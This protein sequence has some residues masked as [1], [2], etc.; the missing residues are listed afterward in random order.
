[1]RHKKIKKILC[2]S[3]LGISILCNTTGCGVLKE[4]ETTVLTQE[5]IFELNKHK[6]TNSC[7]DL[8]SGQ[9]YIWHDEDTENIEDDIFKTKEEIEEHF[10][11]YDYNVFTPVSKYSSALGNDY[12]SQY[13]GKSTRI[14]WF[15]DEQAKEIPHLKAGDKLIYYTTA[16]IILPFVFEHFDNLG[17]SVGVQGVTVDD[18]SH[19][20][21]VLDTGVFSESSSF[22]EVYTKIKADIA[23]VNS[24]A[25]KMVIDKI[26]DIDFA[27]TNVDNYYKIITGLQPNGKYKFDVY[28]GT[29]H[30]EFEVTADCI[31]LGSTNK[32]IILSDDII[33]DID[34]PE[35]SSLN[36]NGTQ[37]KESNSTYKSTEALLTPDESGNFTVLNYDLYN[38]TI[39]VIELPKEGMVEG[40]YYVN[41]MGFF[42]YEP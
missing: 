21:V 4:E 42:Y 17:Y 6:S 18:S 36:G 19:P 41:N 3:I 27:N 16:D 39:A 20:Y 34:H 29:I 26:N 9:F 30:N 10:E 5:E 28:Y 1:M 25:R 11:D 40:Y 38:S 37:Q 13:F 14:A 32:N 31:T 33:G 23:A 12:G 2:T 24:S 8:V 35:D 7:L 22:Y 15:T